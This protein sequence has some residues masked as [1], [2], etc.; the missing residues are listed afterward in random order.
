MAPLTT[1]YLLFLLFLFL[2]SIH[3]QWT[4]DEAFKETLLRQACFNTSDHE[5]C[6]SRVKSQHCHG[7]DNLAGPISILHG[8]V[9]GTIDE[10][11][12]TVSNLAAVSSDLHEEMAIH[13]CVELLGYSIDELGWSLQE[14]GRLISSNRST[15]NEANHRAWLSATLNNQDKC[16]EGFEATDGRVKQYLE[17]RLTEVMMLVSNFLMMYKKMCDIIPHASAPPPGNGSTKSDR[18][19]S[20]PLKLEVDCDDR[21]GG[22]EEE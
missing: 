12:C 16:L 21:G 5:A 4:Q 18:N 1:N 14:I 6:I 11:V 19:V 3:A 7:N 20:S 8:A 10:A 9:K 2:R 13:D 22:V 17:G 15:H